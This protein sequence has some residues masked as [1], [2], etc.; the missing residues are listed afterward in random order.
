[1]GFL[2]PGI[3][4]FQFLKLR[5]PEWRKSSRSVDSVNSEFRSSEIGFYDSENLE[6][7]F[8]GLQIQ[9]PVFRIVVSGISSCSAFF[10]ILGFR[11]N[12]LQY[13]LVNDL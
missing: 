13:E 4:E 5:I 6:F 11:R 7:L 9:I 8:P 1:M 2:N 3:L 12:S 10:G